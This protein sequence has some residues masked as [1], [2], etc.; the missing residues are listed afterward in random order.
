MSFPLFSWIL[1]DIDIRPQ[2]RST[3][4][5][6]WSRHSCFW[7]LPMQPQCGSTDQASPS[8][9]SESDPAWQND[10]YLSL[11]SHFTDLQSF[12]G[13]TNHVFLIFFGA[14]QPALCIN[15]CDEE[16]GRTN[17]GRPVGFRLSKL[18]AGLH[19]LANYHLWD[20]K[21]KNV[22]TECTVFN[23]ICKSVGRLGGIWEASGSLLGIWRTHAHTA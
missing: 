11:A 23:S 1:N 12:F 16:R 17:I 18:V 5:P 15:S 6:G 20:I 3:E 7:E 8:E 2:A 21:V 14:S 4:R 10:T 19:G 13:A 22:K 9:S